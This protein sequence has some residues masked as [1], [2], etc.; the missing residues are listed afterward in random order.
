MVGL[1]LLT[2][3]VG[4]CRGGSW[5]KTS[6]GGGGW[7]KT[8]EYRHMG[9]RVKNFSKYRH[10]IFERSLSKLNSNSKQWQ[11]NIFYCIRTVLKTDAGAKL[12]HFTQKRIN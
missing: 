2:V 5:L 11:V 3:Y 6:Y 4:I 9:G 7:Q 10:M 1:P 12:L 8:S